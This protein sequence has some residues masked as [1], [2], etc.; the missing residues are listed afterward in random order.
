MSY[1]WE[2]IDWEDDVLLFSPHQA[3]INT[4]HKMNQVKD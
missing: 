3:Y 2:L 4:L 1:V